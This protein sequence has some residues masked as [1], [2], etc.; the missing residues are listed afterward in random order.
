[1]TRSLLLRQQF[2]NDS[3]TR[4]ADVVENITLLLLKTETRIGKRERATC[5]LNASTNTTKLSIKTNNFYLPL[6]FFF[7]VITLEGNVRI[8]IK[9]SP[10][11]YVMI[12]GLI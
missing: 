4:N 3:L 5:I 10:Y 7:G 9:L 11:R 2:Q 6:F 1:M 8:D 12:P